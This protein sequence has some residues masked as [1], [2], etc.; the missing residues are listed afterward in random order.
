MVRANESFLSL[1]TAG[2]RI[3]SSRG[4]AVAGR[5][6]VSEFRDMLATARDRMAAMV[7]KRMTEEEALVARPFSDL[8]PK[9]AA[10]ERESINFIR[11]A[12]NSFTRS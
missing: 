5:T 10:N 2:T 12:Y 11:V 8:D 9:W 3:V 4:A 7:D 6:Q 1:T